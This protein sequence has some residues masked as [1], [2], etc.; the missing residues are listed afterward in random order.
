MYFC[1]DAFIEPGEVEVESSAETLLGVSELGG[2]FHDGHV[3]EGIIMRV[4]FAVDFNIIGEDI[5]LLKG[6]GQFMLY[7]G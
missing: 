5:C 4:V 3:S 2:F 6:L 1:H 7:G